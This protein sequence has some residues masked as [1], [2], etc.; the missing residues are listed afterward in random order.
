MPS[1]KTGAEVMPDFILYPGSILSGASRRTA[2]PVA[3]FGQS[4]LDTLPVPQLDLIE[5]LNDKESLN[6]LR[7]ATACCLSLNHSTKIF[8]K[9]AAAAPQPVP[10]TLHFSTIA[11]PARNPY[12]S[13]SSLKAARK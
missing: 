9:P 4:S 6:S 12:E 13:R 5:K 7:A 3:A 2:E 1:G 10:D 8:L 11:K